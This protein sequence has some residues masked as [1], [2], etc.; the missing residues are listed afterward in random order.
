MCIIHYMPRIMYKFRPECLHCLKHLIYLLTKPIKHILGDNTDRITT[1]ELTQV[2][3][4]PELQRSVTGRKD[5]DTTNFHHFWR[6][7]CSLEAWKNTGQYLLQ[8]S[9]SPCTHQ[10]P[11]LAKTAVSTSSMPVHSSW[12]FGINWSKCQFLDYL[13]I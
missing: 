1:R 9:A 5:Q 11:T 12:D 4:M 3:K 10:W 6:K 7:Q 8:T 2:T 13:S